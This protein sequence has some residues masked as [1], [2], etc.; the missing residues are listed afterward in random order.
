MQCSDAVA[1]VVP[2]RFF[3]QVAEIGW[4]IEARVAGNRRDS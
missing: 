1:R 4:V 3:E 2:K